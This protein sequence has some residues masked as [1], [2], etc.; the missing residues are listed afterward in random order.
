M[1]GLSP[2]PSSSLPTIT[3]HAKDKLK[4]QAL[5]ELAGVSLREVLD[6]DSRPTFVLDLD[7]DYIDYGSDH[8]AIQPLFCNA[9][10]RQHNRL[11]DSIADPNAEVTG[12]ED[13]GTT[14]Q[15]FMSWATGATKFDD[16]RDVF[17]LTLTYHNLLWTGSTIR[18]RW[19]IVSG[20]QYYY[21][22]HLPQEGL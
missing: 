15:E 18:R 1:S 14:Y 12:D 7:S 19:R 6:Q 16:S 9:A 22:S 2:Q 3:T 17:P 13:N 8:E 21:N 4:H 11:L 10:L 5:E 20:Y